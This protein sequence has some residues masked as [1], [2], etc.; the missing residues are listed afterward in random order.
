MYPFF[1]SIRCQEGQVQHLEYHQRRVALHSHVILTERVEQLDTPSEGV[2]KLRI[3]YN[4]HCFGDIR[5]TPYTPTEIKTL[6]LIECN[7]IEYSTKYNDRTAIN[8][9]YDLREE[10]DD[11]L[12]VKNGWITDSSFCNIL[13]FNGSQ[14]I[15]PKSCLLRGSCRERLLEEGII[16]QRDVSIDNLKNYISFMLVNAMMDFDPR[17]A[18]ST[19][20]IIH[21]F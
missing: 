5:I 2:H 3:S 11:I 1:E 7:E 4:Q 6:K 19:E 20:N 18:I 10:A 12:I 21:S 15:T 16:E 13:L 9:L 17:R 14:W 8:L